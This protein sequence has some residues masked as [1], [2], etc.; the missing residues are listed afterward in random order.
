MV[1]QAKRIRELEEKVNTIV[2]EN[3]KEHGKMEKNNTQDHGDIKLK[4]QEVG[5]SVKN[6]KENHLAHMYRLLWWVMGVLAAILVA[7]IVNAVKL[8]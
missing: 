6:L 4:V 8:G 3:S 5:N 2:L 1:D 7:L